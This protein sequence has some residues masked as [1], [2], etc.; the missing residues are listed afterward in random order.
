MSFT[1]FSFVTPWLLLGLP[2]AA[3]PLL[4]HLISSRRAKEVPFP[5]LRFLQQSMHR[6]AKRR[7]VQHWALMILR[8]GLLAALAIGAAGLIVRGGEHFWGA[9]RYAAVGILDNSYSMQTLASGSSRLMGAKTGL[10]RLLD[11]PGAPSSAAVLLTH[12]PATVGAMTTHQKPLSEQVE[13]TTAGTVGEDAARCI[14]EAIALLDAQGLPDK[15]I[16]LFGDLQQSTVSPEAIAEAMGERTDIRL[17]IV[18]A[19]DGPVA[20]VGVTAL[21]VHGV[22]VVDQPFRL[23]A[24]LHNSS[25]ADARVTLRLKIDGRTV[26]QPRTVTIAGDAAAPEV[27]TFTHAF[28]SPGVYAGEV[29]IDEADD[30]A[31]DD[32]RWFAVNVRDRAKVL[33]VGGPAQ[34]APHA[35]GARV[36]LFALDPRIDE[37]TP[38]SIRP[39]MVRYDA[40]TP[41]D[42]QGVRAVFCA[43][44]PTFTA[45]QATALIEYV[46]DG[47]TA[48]LF[49]G[50]NVD[51]AAY[52]A[53]FIDQPSAPPGPFLPARLTHPVGEIGLRAPALPL[54]EVAF[55]HPWFAGL[56]MAE[57][58]VADIL[59]QRRF[60]VEITSANTEVLMRLAG[61]DPLVLTAPYG[62]GRVVLCTTTASLQWTKLPSVGLALFVPML[63]R[64]CLQ[65]GR[66]LPNP[67]QAGLGVDIFLPTDVAAGDGLI[68]TSPSG[69]VSERAVLARRDA[70]RIRAHF[71]EVDE[72]G[73]YRWTGPAGAAAAAAAGAFAF[74]LDG[75]ESDLTP[76]DPEALIAAVG[77]DRCFVAASVAEV[78]AAA[79][80]RSAGA[81]LSEPFLA[82]VAIALI[83]EA[84]ICNRRTRGRPG[85]IKA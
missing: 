62:R 31:V 69:R 61:G 74:N 79:A 54:A 22:P 18:N 25:P 5:T 6:T 84:A 29:A 63:E 50:P 10:R 45:A 56:S 80:A 41:A 21:A 58:D 38:W 14:A 33:I 81:N 67:G 8:S 28:S 55:D 17:M 53:L 23:V 1:A 35:D 37:R 64:F 9:D 26:G 82:V 19:A 36:L 13:A 11:G 70:D 66:Q 52:N 20:N 75:S 39:R 2:A 85:E 83:L 15:R 4:L 30:L 47:G 12:G 76:V 3:I 24:T 59:T 57:D 42:L 40:F 46:G 27:V 43:N 44:V 77:E 60:G 34:A 73:V 51:A 72:L 68:L 49:G 16:Y 65:S 32:R 71:A 78:N 7:R 48:V